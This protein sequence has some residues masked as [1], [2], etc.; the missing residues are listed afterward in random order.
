MLVEPTL[1]PSLDNSESDLHIDMKH[2]AWNVKDQAWKRRRHLLSY[3]YTR[4]NWGK[5]LFGLIYPRP[6]H[7]YDHAPQE[8]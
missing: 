8:R 2:E 5:G 3:V 1:E 6:L 7:V 4:D